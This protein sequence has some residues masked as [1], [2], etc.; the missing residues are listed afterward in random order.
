MI[1]VSATEEEERK[2]TIA[3]LGGARHRR[4]RGDARAIL[5]LIIQQGSRPHIPTQRDCKIQRSVDPE[6]HQ[7][8]DQAL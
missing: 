7:A 5:D 1:P 8:L 2:A 6:I 4:Q 3:L